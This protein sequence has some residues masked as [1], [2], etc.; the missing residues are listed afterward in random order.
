M[1]RALMQMLCVR[2]KHAEG[3]TF[4]RSCVFSCA[5]SNAHK[6]RVD[7]FHAPSV[8]AA[9]H[10]RSRLPRSI[11]NGGVE[12]P[13]EPAGACSWVNEALRKSAKILD[14]IHSGSRHQRTEGHGWTTGTT[15]RTNQHHHHREKSAKSLAFLEWT[16]SLLASIRLA[17]SFFS[18]FFL[19][20]PC[21]FFLFI[22]LPYLFAERNKI[23]F[24]K[25]MKNQRQII[26]ILF[27]YTMPRERNKLTIPLNSKS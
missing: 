10:P 23:T 13:G 18:F 24:S 27:G 5:L 19:C 22:F 6:H 16:R 20:L 15:C 8:E 25:E 21:V 2:S 17:Q 14:S 4:E 11:L 9:N 1:S 3:C 7:A 12:S 26:S